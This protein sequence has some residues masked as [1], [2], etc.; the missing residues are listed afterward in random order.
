MRDLNSALS[1]SRAKL[2]TIIF[3]DS[4]KIQPNGV[5]AYT[6][7]QFDLVSVKEK[8]LFSLLSSLTQY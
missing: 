5:C 7:Y 6:S 8:G 3:P 1:D 2:S 4:K